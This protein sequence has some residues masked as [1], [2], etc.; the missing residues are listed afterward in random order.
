MKRITRFG[1]A[2]TSLIIGVLY[3][4]LTLIFCLPVGGLMFLLGGQNTS[5][6]IF[7]IFAPILY[8]ITGYLGTLLTLWIYNLLAK[9]LGGIEIEVETT[10]IDSPKIEQEVIKS[11]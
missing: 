2:Q 10:E 7:L 5:M 8:G 3:F 9:R 4:V 11:V 1:L 6:G